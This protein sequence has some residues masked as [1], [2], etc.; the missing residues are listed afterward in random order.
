MKKKI[1]P[2]AKKFAKLG[3]KIFATHHTADIFMEN[4]INV[5][6]LNKVS[7]FRI[8]PNIMD[9]ILNR[10]LDLVINI[11]FTSKNVRNNQILEDE[12]LIR[13]K[14][15]EFNI[16]VITDLQLVDALIE[17]LEDLHERG[18]HD[19]KTYYEKVITR[20]LD[21]YHDMLREIYW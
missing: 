20:S 8:K 1:I 2:I 14:A 19:L 17:A 3:H 16:P 11:P 9:F 21:E 18:I 15:L 6:I 5:E 13:R 10:N 4:G 7:D 12:Y